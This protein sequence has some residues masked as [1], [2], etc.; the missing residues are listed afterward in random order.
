MCMPIVSWHYISLS[1]LNARTKSF[2]GAADPDSAASSSSRRNA[3]V[4]FE[5]EDEAPRPVHIHS[6][7]T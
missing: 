2:A 7:D 1:M 5:R 4:E 3:P 6:R